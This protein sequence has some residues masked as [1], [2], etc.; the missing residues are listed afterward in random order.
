LVPA[1][2]ESPAGVVRSLAA[3]ASALDR[4]W[5]PLSP[6]AWA[7]PVVEPEDNPDLGPT[8]LSVLAVL[9]LTEIEVHGTDLDAGLGPWS[10][11]FVAAA[12][13]TRLERLNLRRAA[14]DGSWLLVATD[15]PSWLV[16]AAGSTVRSLPADPAA[17]ADATISG[18]ARD[19][20]ALLLGRDPLEPLVLGGDES[21]AATF[22]DAFPGP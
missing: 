19:L 20:L 2:G 21:M 5:A 1:E 12:L 18:T 22:A 10:S 13:P 3:E 17:H 4:L 6:G 15:G 7:T 8:T 9:R 16:T 11:T 14:R